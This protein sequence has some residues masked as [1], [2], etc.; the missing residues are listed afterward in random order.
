MSTRRGRRTG[1]DNGKRLAQDYV[2]TVC[3]DHFVE[4]AATSPERAA[5]AAEKEM[6]SRY[7]LASSI[8]IKEVEQL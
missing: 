3:V 6:R 7:A 8:T 4:V 1:Y 2:V 5:A